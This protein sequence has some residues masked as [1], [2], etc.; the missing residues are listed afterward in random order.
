MDDLGESSLSLSGVVDPRA[1]LE[2]AKMVRVL[3]SRETG[4]ANADGCRACAGC[5][6][7]EPLFSGLA[8]R[9][10]VYRKWSTLFAN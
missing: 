3:L 10:K 8:V 2:L 1:E 4:I 7:G 5:D 6:W 9:L